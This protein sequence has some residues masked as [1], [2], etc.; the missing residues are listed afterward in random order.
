MAIADELVSS[1][2]LACL[3]TPAHEQY[4]VWLKQFFLGALG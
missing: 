3:S 1:P 2:A 4:Q